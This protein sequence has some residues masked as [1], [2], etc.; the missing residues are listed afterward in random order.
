MVDE[1]RVDGEWTTTWNGED[2]GGFPAPSFNMYTDCDVAGFDVESARELLS[3]VPPA[4]APERDAIGVSVPGTGCPVFQESFNALY[5]ASMGEA[6]TAD[7]RRMMMNPNSTACSGPVTVGEEGPGGVRSEM[8]YAL[9]TP[10]PVIEARRQY[11][12][13]EQSLNAIPAHEIDSLCDFDDRGIAIPPAPDGAPCN[14]RTFHELGQGTITIWT[15]YASSDGPNVIIRGDF[16]WGH[17]RYRCHHCDA[18][19]PEVPRIVAAMEVFGNTGLG[20][21]GPNAEVVGSVGAP[22]GIIG[23][24]QGVDEVVD[25]DL[26]ELLTDDPYEAAVIAGLIAMAGVIGLAGATV[27]E[28]RLNRREEE[29]APPTDDERNVSVWDEKNK[30][31]TWMT[32]EQADDWYA[33]QREK[34]IAAHGKAAETDLQAWLDRWKEKAKVEEAL[35]AELIRKRIEE[36][37]RW[38]DWEERLKGREAL[39]ERQSLLEADSA[40]KNSTAGWWDMFLDEYSEGVVEDWKAIP[41]ELY[42]AFGNGIRK[43]AEELTDIENYVVILETGWDSAVDMIRIATG[44][45][46]KA[47]EVAQ[48]MHDAV[49]TVAQVAGTLYAGAENDPAGA[50]AGLAKVLLGVENWQKATSKDTQVTERFARVLWGIIETG[51]TLWGAGAAGV[52][53]LDKFGDIARGADRLSD[54]GKVRLVADPEG[55][56]RL[57]AAAK[58]RREAQAGLRSFGEMIEGGKLPRD[59]WVRNLPEGAVIERNWLHEI[60]Y[61]QEQI[62]AMAAIARARPGKPGYVISSRATNMDSMH[63]IRTGDAIRKPPE[64]KA[65]T[66]N[67]LDSY[68]GA[69]DADVGLVGYF[70][71]DPPTNVPKGLEGVV[72]RRYDERVKEYNDLRKKVDSMV[73]YAEEGGKLMKVV[74]DGDEIRHDSLRR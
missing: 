58:A 65:K 20:N 36:E 59:A 73:D 51:G 62:D 53:V 67:K 46:E 1:R 48:T 27:A 33:E 64:I 2:Q 18:D 11:E 38:A 61:S 56:A 44:D 17:Y 21:F 50:A 47:R 35:A 70:R 12:A 54:A 22:E 60:G 45:T 41:G 10:D 40:R 52:K 6:P 25:P 49:A 74:R 57:R 42:D 5:D 37:A 43:V 9:A 29:A 31:A 72:Q 24:T 30:K 68:I 15:D 23:E 13:A 19:S 71:P 55:F 34:E 8:R 66:I 26:I 28:E 4:T 63:W 14:L 39:E 32:Q 69:S 16:P 7:L 3:P